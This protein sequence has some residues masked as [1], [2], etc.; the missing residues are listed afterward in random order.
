MKY[1]LEQYDSNRQGQE[2]QNQWMNDNAADKGWDTFGTEGWVF[3]SEKKTEEPAAEDPGYYDN[4]YWQGSMHY[5][6]EDLLVEFS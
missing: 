3:E 5:T 6:I 1:N 2:H 4:N